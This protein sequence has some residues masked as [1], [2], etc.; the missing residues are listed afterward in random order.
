MSQHQRLHYAHG[1]REPPPAR[2]H[3]DTP[4]NK[5]PLTQHFFDEQY[6]R[7]AAIWE[8]DINEVAGG[9]PEMARYLRLEYA[10]PRRTRPTT[11]GSVAMSAQFSV[12]EEWGFPRQQTLE[13]VI[14]NDDVAWEPWRRPMAEG[15]VRLNDRPMEVIREAGLS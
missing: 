6:A 1:L 2:F 15:A 3:V 7:D 13:N 9:N 10:G 14:P 12:V 5:T 8:D 11:G 4:D